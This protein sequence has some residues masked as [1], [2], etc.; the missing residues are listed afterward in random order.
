M[1]AALGGGVDASVRL[2]ENTAFQGFGCV[3]LE[4]L[5]GR[6]EVVVVVAP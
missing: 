1:H 4:S 3:V 2:R 5:F 6:L